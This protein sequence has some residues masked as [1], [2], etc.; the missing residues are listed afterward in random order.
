MGQFFSCPADIKVERSVVKNLRLALSKLKL[1]EQET[2][3]EL[4]YKTSEYNKARERVSDLRKQLK[5]VSEDSE[6]SASLAAEEMREK[7]R[8]YGI[9]VDEYKFTISSLKAKLRATRA[10]E[11]EVKNALSLLEEKYKKEKQR[12]KMLSTILS[13]LNSKEIQVSDELAKR[14]TQLRTASNDI[15]NLKKLI[16]ESNKSESILNQ[17]LETKTKEYKVLE[18]KSSSEISKLS[19]LLTSVRKDIA[20]TKARLES[21][22]TRYE[23]EQSLVTSLKKEKKDVGNLL[24][25]CKLDK[26]DISSKANAKLADVNA[27]LVV[28]KSSL[29][30]V[31]SRLVVSKSSLAD[32]NSQ[33]TVAKSKE[34]TKEQERSLASIKETNRHS[35][36]NHVRY[37]T[38]LACLNSKICIGLNN[39]NKTIGRHNYQIT[40]LGRGRWYWHDSDRKRHNEQLP[41]H[42]WTN[43][44]QWARS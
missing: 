12:A 41:E 30:D 4:N 36:N 8:E 28:A 26:K 23:G 43:S 33:L 6:T 40:P 42:V 44:W 14:K 13:Q 11:E 29:A 34:M 24:N 27:K 21:V 25:A 20:E 19:K 5:G 31:N 18:S 2:V 9:I 17:S 15:K 7:K 38:L 1:Q 37:R 35:H 22:R 39:R 16:D 10:E 3:V 32:V